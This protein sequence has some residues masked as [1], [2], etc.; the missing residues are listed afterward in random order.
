MDSHDFR[1]PD[2]LDAEFSRDPV[3]RQLSD[4]ERA[5]WVLRRWM[6]DAESGE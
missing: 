3:T 2:E 4:E 5:A 6:P 1:S